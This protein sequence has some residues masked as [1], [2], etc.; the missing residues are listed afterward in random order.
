MAS[1]VNVLVQGGD[2]YSPLTRG[3]GTNVVRFSGPDDL[4]QSGQ[5]WEQNRRQLA[6]KPFVMSES[7]GSGQLVAFTQDPTV[8]GYLEGLKPLLINAIFLGPAHS[9]P[10]W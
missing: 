5:I 6:F 10:Q 4:V 1:S 9:S 7:L 3:Q 8:R 2:I